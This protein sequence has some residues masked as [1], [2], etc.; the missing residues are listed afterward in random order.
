MSS[1]TGPQ[2][3]TAASEA[4]YSANLLAVFTHWSV[5]LHVNQYF[6]GR[7]YIWCHRPTAIDVTDLNS[8]E[9]TELQLVIRRSQSV[10]RTVFDPTLFNQG[11]L[12]NETARCHVHIVPRYESPRTFNDIL[13][14][15]TLFGGNWGKYDKDQDP[16]KDRP[17]IHEALCV[18]LREQFAQH[19]D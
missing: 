17:G 7:M 5:Y 11:S 14:T 2:A 12:G 18:L 13:F 6:L 19:T 3:P 4:E 9:W 15:D 10:L 16:I 8:E 1:T